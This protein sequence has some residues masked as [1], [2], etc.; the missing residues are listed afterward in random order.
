[1]AISQRT[2][3]ANRLVYVD[4]AG[5]A[6]EILLALLGGQSVWDGRVSQSI[7]ATT[8]VMS[9]VGLPAEVSSGSTVTATDVGYMTLAGLVAETSAGSSVSV[10][11]GELTFTGLAADVSAGSTVDAEVGSLALVGLDADVTTSIGPVFDPGELVFEGLEASV[12]VSSDVAAEAGVLTFAGSTAEISVGSTVGAVAGSLTLDGYV[13]EVSSGSTVTATDVGYMTLSGLAAEISS[14]ST[15]TASTTPALTLTGLAADVVVSVLKVAGA[16]K[17]GVQQLADSAWAAM[18]AAVVRAGFGDTVLSGAS[19]VMSGS[20][21]IT[22]TGKMTLGGASSTN[23]KGFRILKNG[24]VIQKFTNTNNDRLA[25]GTTSSFS[26]AT[27]D[28]IS[29]EFYAATVW[30]NDRTVQPGSTSTYFYTALV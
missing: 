24:T 10:S 21:S 15:V 30:A 17:S 6:H 20:G 4:E 19:L 18:D 11:G 23:T 25:A 12:S 28:L 1:M 29:M 3:S 14:G 13:A 2:E 8:G 27:G 16:D 9:F 5:V 26:V 22:V 7:P